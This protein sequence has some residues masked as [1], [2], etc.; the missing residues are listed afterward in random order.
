MLPQIAA[1]LTRPGQPALAVL[2]D[3][4]LVV[5]SQT[6][7]VVQAKLDSEPFV[8]V[9]HCRPEPKLRPEF[10]GRKSTRRLDFRPNK[11]GH[12]GT[13]LSAHAIAD[14][15]VIPRELFVGHAPDP[16]RQLS[17]TAVT[18]LQQWYALRYSRPAWPDAFNARFDNKAKK[19]LADALRI[20]TIDDVEV[21]VAIAE[22]GRELEADQPYHVA[23][24]FVVDQTVWDYAPD[25]RE[26]AHKAFAEFVSTLAGC[27]GLAVD[28]ELSGV[29]S[30]DD[31][32]WQLTRT[33]DEW[34]FAN[35]SEQ[36]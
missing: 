31:F 25:I 35:L 21:R 1:H 18:N 11:E 36:D 16:G 23:V 4:W 20:L 7:D 29:K 26:Q 30:G 15:Y 9:L 2:E 3:H 32:S 22:N 14:R 10:Q 17:G 33:T 8:E 28:E 34:N 19:R 5:V 24:F 13:V 12:A 27:A 6:C